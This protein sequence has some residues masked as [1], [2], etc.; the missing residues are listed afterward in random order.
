MRAT[1]P[2]HFIRLDL[3]YLM[4]SGRKGFY[5]TK[6]KLLIIHGSR[7]SS[8]SIVSDYGLDD[9]AIEIRSQAWA[10]DFS[11]SLCVQT[12]SEAHPASCTMGTRGKARPGRDTDDSPPSR[13]QEWVG[14]I[15]PLPPSA[16]MAC[17]GTALLFYLLRIRSWAIWFHSTPSHHVSRKFI[18]IFCSHLY[19]RLQSYVLPSGFWIKILYTFF[20]SFKR[21]TCSTHLILDLVII[22]ILDGDQFFFS[23]LWVFQP[24]V[25]SSMLAP[26]ILL[27]TL[28]TDS[29]QCENH[30]SHPYTRQYVK[31]QFCI[32][33]P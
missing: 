23:L 16:S 3:T 13:G 26:N 7:V 25:T 21:A 14:T 30:L 5:F 32:I 24:P 33:S 8:V 10:K 15:P 17:S 22:I 18:L 20:I 9:R 27:N 11:S 29:P 19:L 6:T 2:A 1:C 31:L 28:L 4:I 12:G